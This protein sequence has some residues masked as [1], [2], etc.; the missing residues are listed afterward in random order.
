[1]I[2]VSVGAGASILQGAVSNI[3]NGDLAKAEADGKMIT[4]LKNHVIV[5]GYSHLGK[6]VAQ[7]LEDIGLDYV[8]E[9]DCRKSRNLPPLSVSL[10]MISW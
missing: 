8:M 10:G 4:R 5:F 3:V 2:I 7:K 1:M 9:R 6:H